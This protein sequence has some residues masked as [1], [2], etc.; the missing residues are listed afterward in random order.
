MSKAL[1]FISRTLLGLFFVVVGLDGFFNFLP[2]APMPDKANALIAAL[3]D[4]GYMW[5]LAKGTMIGAGALLLVDVFT[6]IA[7][8]ALAPVVLNIFLFLFFLNPKELP[9]GVIIGVLELVV[10]WFY[11]DS[12]AGILKFRPASLAN[13]NKTSTA[14]S[15]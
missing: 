10:T 1:K 11:F 3:I 14:A 4:S 13:D 2:L 12:F 8:I 7:L 5:Q 9:I 6:P 15:N